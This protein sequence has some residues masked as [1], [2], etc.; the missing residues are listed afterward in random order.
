[1]NTEQ[2][3]NASAP[4]A[5]RECPRYATCS[6][7]ICPLDPDWRGRCHMPGDRVCIW[8]TELAKPGGEEQVV[9]AITSET[10]R[11]VAQTLPDI[12]AHWGAIRRALDKSSRKG[13]RLAAQQLLGRSMAARRTS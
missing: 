6:A 8:L 9:A 1:M 10:T 12:T 5:M 3:V 2:P 4:M 13:S 7:P 11:F